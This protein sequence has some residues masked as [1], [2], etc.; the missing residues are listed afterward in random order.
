MKKIL[1]FF[2]MLIFSSQTC[3][4]IN[5]MKRFEISVTDFFLPFLSTEENNRVRA[6]ILDEKLTIAGGYLSKSHIK[7]MDY[8]SLE[9]DGGDICF[10][11]CTPLSHST[12]TERK[13]IIR[14]QQAKIISL[15]PQ[16]HKVVFELPADLE[17]TFLLD[18]IYFAFPLEALRKQAST[19]KSLSASGS[20]KKH[21]ELHIP[22]TL[23]DQ[24]ASF[25]HYKLEPRLYFSSSS[26]P[27]SALVNFQ[28]THGFSARLGIAVKI[29]LLD[30]NNA[31]LTTPLLPNFGAELPQSKSGTLGGD[32]D[33]IRLFGPTNS[34]T[35]TS[36]ELSILNQ[37]ISFDHGGFDEKNLIPITLT[38]KPPSWDLIKNI[39]ANFINLGHIKIILIQGELAYELGK[40]EYISQKNYQTQETWIQAGDQI[41]QVHGRPDKNWSMS[42][43]CYFSYYITFN[44]DGNK[45]LY[46]TRDE[47][48]HVFFSPL[49]DNDIT[50]LLDFESR[51]KEMTFKMPSA[52]KACLQKIDHTKRL[53][54]KTNTELMNDFSIFRKAI[55]NAR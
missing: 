14:R 51:K 42:D 33:S 44:S 37:S 50:P 36:S 11:N 28:D 47:R 7:N 16:E 46:F 6:Q 22:I 8:K 9:K 4:A 53:F 40:G 1:F 41:I 18:T 17:E 2:L 23:D 27:Y 48:S 35:Y 21:L 20:E 54:N 32:V 39:K 3:F 30:E 13:N 10:W 5:N 29:N 26:V 38:E 49:D 45:Q 31:P 19:P 34:A 15:N 52:I 12:Q 55:E 43:Q 25:N 24:Q